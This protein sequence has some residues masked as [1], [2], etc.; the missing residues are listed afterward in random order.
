MGL[1]LLE[2]QPVCLCPPVLGSVCCDRQGE[3]INIVLILL[4]GQLLKGSALAR[5]G[6]WHLN[7]RAFYYPQQEN[8]SNIPVGQ[9]WD[10]GKSQLPN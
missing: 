9:T 5:A 10:P 4:I 7:I 1:E 6:K 8:D 2:H 3:C